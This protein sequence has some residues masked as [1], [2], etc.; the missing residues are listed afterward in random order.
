MLAYNIKTKMSRIHRTIYLVLLL[1][2]AASTVLPGIVYAQQNEVSGPLTDTELLYREALQFYKEKK[3][4][5]ARVKFVQV[6]MRDKHYKSTDSF[7]RRLDEQLNFIEKKKE[8]E[9]AKRARQRKK[10]A[11]MKKARSNK[12]DRKLQREL[13]RQKAGR[14]RKKRHEREKI[15]EEKRRTRQER[16]ALMRRKKREERLARQKEEQDNRQQEWEEK[17]KEELEQKKIAAEEALKKR[18]EVLA[19]K[20]KDREEK[21]AQKRKLFEQSEKMGKVRKV[22]SEAVK[23]YK[24][25]EF[26]LAKYKLDDVKKMMSATDF[27][28]KFIADI[29]A[30]HDRLTEKIA[31]AEEKERFLAQRKKQKAEDRKAAQKEK[32]N[33]RQKRQAERQQRL[34]DKRQISLEKPAK[35]GDLGEVSPT[36]GDGGQKARDLTLKQARIDALEKQDQSALEPQAPAM[37]PEEAAAQKAE[38]T[39]ELERGVD[40]LYRDGIDLFRAGSEELAAEILF[41][42]DKIWPNYKLTRYY[43]ELIAQKRGMD[44]FSIPQGASQSSRLEA[45]EEALDA[46][47]P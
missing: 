19:Q 24:K 45:V 21:L 34:Q 4:E 27:A 46:F 20:K 41:Q 3:F 25:R 13:A 33:I 15:E 26:H 39:E 1:A 23:F 32:E 31:L 10:K 47:K 6:R 22:Y 40:D 16:R 37:S 35:I 11:E 44:A 2:F 8:E 5:K 43:L 12:M 18:K 30:K 9:S 42:V 38:L 14:E 17:H 29:R 7:L 36:Q 28:E